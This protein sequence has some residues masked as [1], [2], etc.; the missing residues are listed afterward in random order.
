MKFVTEND[1]VLPFIRLDETMTGPMTDVLECDK[2]NI[3]RPSIT[4][5]IVIAFRS[6]SIGVTVLDGYHSLSLY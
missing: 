3:Y 2:I 5:Y 6:I 1:T 4:K